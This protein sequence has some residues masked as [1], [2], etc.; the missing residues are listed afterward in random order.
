MRVSVEN[1]QKDLWN[2]NVQSYRKRRER[3]KKKH[4]INIQIEKKENNQKRF[5]CLVEIRQ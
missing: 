1:S 4:R 3:E 5:C 2:A